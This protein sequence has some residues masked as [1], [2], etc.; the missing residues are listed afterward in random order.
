MIKKDI[1]NKIWEN[2]KSDIYKRDVEKV[3]EELLNLIKN[4]LINGE[5]VKISKFGKFILY[6]RKQR[7]GRNPK[8]MEP[9]IIESCRSMKF[10]PS[11][12]L[13]KYLNS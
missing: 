2:I 1:V 10:K 5:D 4:T 11:K 7:I 12:K 13:K 6:Q 8:T 9:A 3:V